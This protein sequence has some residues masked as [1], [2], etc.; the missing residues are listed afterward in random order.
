MLDGPAEDHQIGETRAVILRFL[1]TTP[2]STP[3][4]IAKGVGLAAGTVRQTCTR[5]VADGQL[6]AEPGGRHRS[7][8]KKTLAMLVS[9]LELAVRDGVVDRNVA[10]VTG[11][12]RAYQQA[13]DEL[14]DPRSLALPDW[15]ALIS[16]ADALVARSH[17]QFTGWD[18]L[19]CSPGAPRPASAR[20]PRRRYRPANLDV[21]RAAADH[22]RSGWLDRQGHQ[23]Q[24]RP[25]GADH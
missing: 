24:V 17:G 14:D 11:W 23:R 13:G 21:D 2:G 15:E 9:V 5:M 19:S 8:V 16:L 12:Q 6:A 7:T 25:Q 18:T 3:K 1:R 10:R 20:C 22:T 4:A